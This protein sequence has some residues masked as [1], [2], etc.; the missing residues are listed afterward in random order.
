MKKFIAIL[1]VSI[2]MIFVAVIVAVSMSLFESDLEKYTKACDSNEG[3]GCSNLGILYYHGDGV[4]QDYFQAKT[5]VE[6][7]CGLNDGR[8]CSNLGMLYAEGKGVKQDYFQAKTYFEKACDLN[9]GGAVL[10][11]VCY[12][13]KERA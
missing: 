8:G 3:V 1:I 13:L 4:K 12:M 6:K 10:I 5:Y 9:V 2:S 7:A 11:L